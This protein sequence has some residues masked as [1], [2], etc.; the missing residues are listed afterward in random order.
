MSGVQTQCAAVLNVKCS[1]GEELSILNFNATRA[2]CGAVALVFISAALCAADA[3]PAESKAPELQP[4]FP[5]HALIVTPQQMASREASAAVDPGLP[6]SWDQTYVVREGDEQLRNIDGFDPDYQPYQLIIPPIQ[7][8]FI[9]IIETDPNL[10][11]FAFTARANSGGN[12]ELIPF[13][14]TA[15]NVT[16]PVFNNL[17][18]DIRKQNTRIRGTPRLVRSPGDFIRPGQIVRYAWTRTGAGE[19]RPKV[20]AQFVGKTGPAT[21]LSSSKITE[22][23]AI[24]FQPFVLGHYLMT[25]TP[26]DLLGEPPRGSQSNGQVFRCAFGNV[27]LPPTTDGMIADSFTPAVNQVITVRPFAIDPETGQDLFTNQTYDF[28][29]GTVLT[30]IDGAVTHAYSQA[31]IYRL[32]CTVV[33]AEGLAATAEDNVI[34]GATLIPKLSFNAKKSIVPEEAG[35][36]EHDIDQLKVSFR[37]ASANPGD[38]IVFAYNRNRFGRMNASDTG[39]EDIVLGN[40]RGFEGRLE[41]ARKMTVKGS[42]NSVAI[43]LSGADFDRTGDP[44]FGRS[45]AKGVF[46]N[47]RIAVAVVPADGSEAKVFL[48]SGNVQ[49]RVL[50]GLPGRVTFAPENAVRVKNTQKEPDPNKQEIE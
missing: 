11:A 38:R 18:I 25:V 17:I 5:N 31:G 22:V 14:I 1:E 32:R 26:R 45:D 21:G 16:N 48:Y 10:H 30:G 2:L 9:N 44:R 47:Q 3:A 36:G 40:G 23:L 50:G 7:P 13:Q 19:R 37:G 34:V 4:S 24:K 41:N 46:K 35:T 29:D 12:T 6:F 33:D 28:G 43:E 20:E 39:T 27:N 15:R 42:R 49:I 8:Q